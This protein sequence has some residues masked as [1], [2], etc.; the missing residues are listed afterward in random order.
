MFKDVVV[1]YQLYNPES[2]KES[3]IKYFQLEILFF[4]QIRFT[5]QMMLV[6]FTDKDIYVYT[7][8]EK[9]PQNV[10]NKGSYSV[11]ING[12]AIHLFASYS[13]SLE[14]GSTWRPVKSL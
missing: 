7:Y 3:K 5:E 14:F 6:S 11:N 8:K 1:S 4:L 13:P 12:K 2:F 10:F 9:A